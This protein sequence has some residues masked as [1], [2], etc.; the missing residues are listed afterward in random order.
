MKNFLTKFFVLTFAVC[1]FFV[2]TISPAEAVIVKGYA[3]IVNGDIDGA[4]KEARKQAMREAVEAAVGVHVQSTTEVANFMV[5]KDEISLKS[6]GY[7]NINRVIKE[8]VRGEIFYVELDVEASA[9]RIREFAQDLKSQLDANVNDSN[10]RGGIMVAVTQ[11]NLSGTYNYTPEFSD[12]INAKLKQ[13]GLRAVTN[14]NVVNYLINNYSAPDVR[15][16]ARAIANQFREEENALLRGVLSE[17]S[18]RKVNGVY[19]ATVHASF[20]LIGLDSS[21]VDVFSKFVKGVASTQSEA[22]FNAKETA[23]RE[24]IDSLAKQAL[25][26]V[27]RET[28]GGYTNIKTTVIVSNVTNYQ[29][30]YPAIK[31]GLANA[32]C[33]VI[34]MTRPNPTTLSFFVSTDAY[35]VIGELVQALIDSIPGIQQGSGSAGDLGATKIQLMF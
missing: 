34:R 31:A 30:Q 13:V 4:K 32:K 11:K 23:T 16:R 8:E 7:V 2:G 17:E 5:V 35:S 20:E 24:A 29:A 15:I 22:I 27:Q 10:S 1:A 9:Q 3:P 26:T 21:E 25:E 33:K 6:D 14:D 19:E 28:R 12:Y 18:V